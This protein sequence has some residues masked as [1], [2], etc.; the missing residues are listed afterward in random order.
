MSASDPKRT[1][2]FALHMSA[3]LLVTS[4]P[5]SNIDRCWSA[6]TLRPR[7]PSNTGR[8]CR[9]RSPN[10]FRNN[11]PLWARPGCE[12]AP[13]NCDR[14]ENKYGDGDDDCSDSDSS[15]QELVFRSG[16]P[17]LALFGADLKNPKQPPA[18]LTERLGSQRLLLVWG[19]VAKPP[20]GA[21]DIDTIMPTQSNRDCL[22]TISTRHQIWAGCR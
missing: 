20:L 17:H 15:K 4:R 6:L 10:V 7:Q 21:P 9:R 19:V 2:D 22:R 16:E 14:A 1:L 11:R 8:R 12:N 5:L 3:Y 13:E 18:R